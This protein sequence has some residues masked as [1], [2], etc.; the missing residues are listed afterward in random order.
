[1]KKLE[2]KIL[3]LKLGLTQRSIAD[4]LGYSE[5]YISQI[6]AGKRKSKAFNE[7]IAR[8]IF[9]AERRGVNI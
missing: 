2:C 8:K 7:Y 9:I 4:S 3:L 1:M 5:S 6:I